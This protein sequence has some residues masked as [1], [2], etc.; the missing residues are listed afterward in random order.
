MVLILI[1]ALAGGIAYLAITDRSSQTGDV[2]LILPGPEVRQATPTSQASKDLQSIP[3]I[4]AAK[5]I[6]VLPEITEDLS[7]IELLAKYPPDPTVRLEPGG[8]DMPAWRRHGRASAIPPE[9]SRLAL[10]ITG[11]GHNRA[12][13]VRAITGA[14]PETSLSFAADAVDLEWWI[15]AARAYGH[16]ALLDIPLQSGAAQGLSPDLGPAENLRRLDAMVARAPM[17]AGVTIIGG[18]AFLGEAAA[19]EPIL[20]K[21]QASGLAVI[22]L[23]VTAPLTL[24]ADEAIMGHVTQSEVDGT[25]RSAV[26]LARRRGAALASVD[27]SNASDLLKEWY[28]SLAAGDEVSLVPVTAL[29]EE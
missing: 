14:A 18:D 6:P 16:E 21:L 1:V 12:D 26:A 15:A 11:L 29:V 7:P 28:D 22:G 27:A 10:V 24:A 2:S 3:A 20:K 25:M 23:P 9:A 19:L 4:P 8:A 5:N 13:T 17:I